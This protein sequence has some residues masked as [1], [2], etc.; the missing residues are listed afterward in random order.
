MA[1][2]RSE[3]R[4]PQARRRSA[5]NPF[6]LQ[7]DVTSSFGFLA[8]R[9][10]ATGTCHRAVADFRPALIDSR[11]FPFNV[12]RQVSANR[13]GCWKNVLASYKSAQGNQGNYTLREAITKHIGVTRAV[14]CQFR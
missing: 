11:L 6:W 5:F 2:P 13:C 4:N 1:E 9:G 7:A 10:R 8:G 3:R 14:V 12:Y